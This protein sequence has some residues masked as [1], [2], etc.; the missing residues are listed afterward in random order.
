VPASLAGRVFLD[1]DNSGTVNGP[2]SGISGVT[3]TLSGGSLTTPLTATADSSGNYSFANLA[4]GTYTVTETQ[5]TS[6]ANQSGKTIVGSAAGTVGTNAVSGITLAASTTAT[7]Y[8]FA[9]IPLVGTGGS[10]FEDTNGNGKKDTGEPGIA[11]VT[12][13]LSGTSVFTGV[14]TPQ[15]VT[16]DT[17]GNYTFTG[18]TPGTY[19]IVETQPAG[20]SN[21]SE[22]NGTP[23]AASV[24]E[25]R[26]MGID[27]TKSSAASGGFNFGEHKGGL[28]SGIV[29]N[30]ANDD[31]VQAASGEPGLAGVKVRLTGTDNQGH[32]VDQTTTTAADG[33]YTFENVPAGIYAVHETS[34]AGFTDGKAKAGTSAGTAGT[35]AITGITFASQAVATGY[36]FGELARADLNLSQ[37]P[38]AASIEPG[39]TVTI[40]YTLKNRGAATATA[41]AVTMNFGGLTF[42]SSS[43][44]TAFS[45]TTKTWTVGDLAAGATQTLRLTFR[46][47]SAGTFT[48]TAHAATTA[49][50][51]SS[52]RISASSMINVGDPPAPAPMMPGSNMFWGTWSGF[53]A[54]TRLW[55]F[56]RFFG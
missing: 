15:T 28:I 46:A 26:F 39:G 41:S 18:L 10:V 44:T 24:G 19:M 30:D 3:I 35:G 36:T 9:E 17:N 51:L 33:L 52:A 1:F 25:N 2:D 54:L 50:E 42:V 13:T 29:F 14:I 21:G 7:G 53:N 5:P 6:P 11:G 8:N 45:S 55:L 32:A 49:T 20:Y 48:P 47:P 22:Q 23:A 16:T 56:S 31:G 27:L 40:T 4:A 38:T 37:S 12:I 34:P 43:N